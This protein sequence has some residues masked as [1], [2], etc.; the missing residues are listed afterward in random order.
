MQ[1]LATILLKHNMAVDAQNMYNRWVHIPKQ[2]SM[3]AFTWVILPARVCGAFHP[4]LPVKAPQRGA[5]RP[6]EA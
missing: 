6:Q 4:H 3:I 5:A 2:R 1:E